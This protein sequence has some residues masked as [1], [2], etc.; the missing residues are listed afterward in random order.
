[1]S[2]NQQIPTISVVM[3]VYNAEL[4]LATA[5][6]SILAQTFDDFE[7]IVVNDGSTDGSLRLLET[8]AA[9][10][11]RI[12]VISRANTGIVG[13]LNDGIALARGEFIARM[14]ADDIAF[15]E[16]FDRQLSYLTNHPK[17]V[18]VGS[19]MLHIDPDGDPI[20]INYW[21]E[22]HDVI[23]AQ[24]LRGGGGL[25]HPTAMIRADTLSHVGGYRT[26]YQWIEDKDLWV[27]LAE[28][29]QLANLPEVLLAYRLHSQS[30]CSRMEEEQQQLL[31]AL[32]TETYARRGLNQPVPKLRSRR[33]RAGSVCAIR[34]KWTRSAARAGYIKTAA[35]HARWIIRRQPW[36]LATWLSV[37]IV[38]F[39]GIRQ[40]LPFVRK[41]SPRKATVPP[42]PLVS[43]AGCEPPRRSA[44]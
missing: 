7:L 43:T 30:V 9:Q 33:Q 29:G 16:R 31:R 34:R 10:D 39:L 42:I 6:E 19:A 2:T 8:L 35:K 26:R 18:A 32:L 23:D 22:T 27:R 44:A 25:A 36:S 38:V 17:C 4:Y 13:A 14:D 20:R 12:R 41:P 5:I 21:A 15:P 11:Q 1:M 3:P 24:L 28:V 40:S 37:G